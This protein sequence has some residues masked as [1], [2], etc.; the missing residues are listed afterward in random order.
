VTG[1]L[2]ARL[3]SGRYAFHLCG[4]SAMVHEATALIDSRFPGSLVFSEVFF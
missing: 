3:P 4:G 1:C 2:A